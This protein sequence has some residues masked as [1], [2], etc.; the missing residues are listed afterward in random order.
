LI[1]QEA[2]KNQAAWVAQTLSSEGYLLNFTVQSFAE[3]DRLFEE[4]S[5][6]GRA[7]AWLRAYPRK[8]MFAIGAYVGET[9]L[10]TI[11]GTEWQVENDKLP[12]DENI[13]L[14]LPTGLVCWPMSRVI[15]R[16]H[17]GD[18]YSIHSYGCL[19]YQSSQSHQSG[20]GN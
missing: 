17:S 15:N 1:N 14:Q 11:T 7:T 5:V 3:L 19:L 16:L 18:E 6:D 10:R 2:I 8:I 4:H 9:L 13:G 12:Q 20:A